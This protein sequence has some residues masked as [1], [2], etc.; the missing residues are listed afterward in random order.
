MAG[1]EEADEAGREAIS[2][3]FK[4]KLSI[5]SNDIKK[6]IRQKLYSKSGKRNG[7]L[8]IPQDHHTIE[9]IELSYSD[10]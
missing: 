10:C 1:N 2:L 7:V 6:S 8:K 5:P 9:E 3:P 4:T